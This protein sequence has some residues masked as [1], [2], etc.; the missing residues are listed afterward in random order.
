M[1]KTHHPHFCGVYQIRNLVTG[2]L[3]IGG[4]VDH[5]HRWREHFRL[6]RTGQHHSVYLQNAWNKYGESNFDFEW[7]EDSTREALRDLEQHYLDT[8]KPVYNMSSSAISPLCGRTT[9]QIAEHTRI[10]HTG[11]KRSSE[12][13]KRMQE[14]AR[15]RFADPS[16]V[17]FFQEIRA[18]ARRSPASVKPPPCVFRIVHIAS[19]TS[20]IGSSAHPKQLWS[21]YRNG[22]VRGRHYNDPL[23]EDWNR[24]GADSFRFEVLE[25]VMDSSLLLAREQVYL[26]RRYALTGNH[27]YNI[28]SHS[29]G[30]TGMK[31]SQEKRAKHS[32]AMRKRLEDPAFHERL[33]ESNRNRVWSPEARAKA[34]EA[35]RKQVC[36]D[37]TR[38]KL[39]ENMRKRMQDPEARAK[40]KEN[41]QKRHPKTS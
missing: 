24:F 18:T 8:L 15:K 3:Y 12:T 23:Q 20:Y 30:P 19:D 32:E 21:I 2:D 13:C 37:E 11:R 22:L 38:A 28:H 31:Y 29:N 34:S 40:A 17:K 25:E 5:M 10:F 41:F 16:F 35:A 39:S 33:R 1:T 14:A 7:V 36:S 9:A 26:D 6:L 4:T 27:G